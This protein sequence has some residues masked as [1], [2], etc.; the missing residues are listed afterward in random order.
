MAPRSHWRTPAYFK[1]PSVTVIRQSRLR[2]CCALLH[3]IF[4]IFSVSSCA[5]LNGPLFT[6]SIK[7][8]YLLYPLLYVCKIVSI[9][10]R[11]YPWQHL[12]S[13][14]VARTIYWWRI[15]CNMRPSGLILT[16]YFFI[17][18]FINNFDVTKTCLFYVCRED[19][20]LEQM[21]SGLNYTFEL[22]SEF[23]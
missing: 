22:S 13:I 9:K 3:V 12:P 10:F 15:S 21:R 14:F 16:A 5:L 20:N 8:K 1:W 4:V 17:L 11:N 2:M 7:T 23:N 6:W 18:M 19:E